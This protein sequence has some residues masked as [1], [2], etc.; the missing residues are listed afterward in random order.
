VSLD[1]CYGLVRVRRREPR[2]LYSH[3]EID[4][5]CLLDFIGCQKDG[6]EVKADTTLHGVNAGDVRMA[7]RKSITDPIH[8]LRTVSSSPV[9]SPVYTL[10]RMNELFILLC[11]PSLFIV[12]GR[13]EMSSWNT[14][15]AYL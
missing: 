13:S 14:Q 9:R 12:D 4:T 8:V 2:P 7:H 10:L 11:F 15:S 5:L 3:L 6:D 1:R